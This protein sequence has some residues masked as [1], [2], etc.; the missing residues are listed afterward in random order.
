ML[1]DKLAESEET[2]RYQEFRYKRM[3][4]YARAVAQTKAG[5]RLLGWVMLEAGGLL[6][7]GANEGRRELASAVYHL[8]DHVEPG[9]AEKIFAEERKHLEEDNLNI[10]TAI[11]KRSEE[12]AT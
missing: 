10:A 11:R 6:Q 5:K 1:N 2:E 4:D 8:L 7:V 12:D 9:L 3:A